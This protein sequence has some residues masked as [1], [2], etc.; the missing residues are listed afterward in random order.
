MQEA[1]LGGEVVWKWPAVVEEAGVLQHQYGGRGREGWLCRIYGGSSGSVEGYGV[2]SGGIW[3][4]K[5]CIEEPDLEAAESVYPAL[6]T[7][8]MLM[9]EGSNKSM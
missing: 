3:W 5:R 7:N 8:C 6:L 9:A 4:K 2:Y 1:G